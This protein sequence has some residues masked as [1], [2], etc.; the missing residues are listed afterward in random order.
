VF[1]GIG[2]MMVI[3]DLSRHFF[4]DGFGFVAVLT[5]LGFALIGLGVWWSK[6]EQ[7]LSIKLRSYLPKDLRELLEARVE[8]LRG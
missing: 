3:G 2:M 5:L 8:S 7:A 4:Q 6:Y 1:G